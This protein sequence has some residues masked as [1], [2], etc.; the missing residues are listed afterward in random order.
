LGEGE[1]QVFKSFKKKGY[2]EE[3]MSLSKDMRFGIKN[4]QMVNVLQGGIDGMRYD[5]QNISQVSHIPPDYPG[6]KMQKKTRIA[7]KDNT[8]V[9]K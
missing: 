2:A 1:S 8:Q 6:G 7:K 4:R 3:G 9:K 5:T